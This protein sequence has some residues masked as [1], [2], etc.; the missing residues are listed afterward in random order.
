MVGVLA[1]LLIVRFSAPWSVEEHF[2]TRAE[3]QAAF[4]TMDVRVVERL[5][6]MEQ[7]MRA[8]NDRLELV[9]QQLEPK[10]DSWRASIT[11]KLEECCATPCPLGKRP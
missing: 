5:D 10:A 3:F 1:N 2:P 11:K 7:S 4:R 9:K 8:T 6:T